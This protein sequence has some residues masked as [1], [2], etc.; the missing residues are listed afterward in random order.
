MALFSNYKTD[1]TFLKQNI[2]NTTFINY[3]WTCAA[4]EFVAYL[5]KTTSWDTKTNKNEYLK[6]Y[7][8][9]CNMYEI[10]TTAVNAFIYRFKYDTLKTD[11]NSTTGTSYQVSASNR[12]TDTVTG[13]AVT[14]PK[15]TGCALNFVLSVYNDYCYPN[16]FIQNCKL[17][18][19]YN[20]CKE[21]LTN[22]A[23]VRVPSDNDPTIFVAQCVNMTIPNCN[24][25][26]GVNVNNSDIPIC[27]TC[28]QGYYWNSTTNQCLPSITPNCLVN[29]SIKQCTSCQ[30]G[31]ALYANPTGVS[32]CFPNYTG[33]NIMNCTSMTVDAV[34]SA[35]S[36]TQLAFKCVA[37]TCINGTFALR[38]NTTLITSYHACTKFSS[39]PFCQGYAL[40]SSG[41]QPI[42]AIP[43]CSSCLTNYYLSTD[44]ANNSAKTCQKRFI[45]QSNCSKQT[46]TADTCDTLG[47]ASGFYLTSGN[48]CTSN[49]TGVYKCAAYDS[50][51]T[52]CQ[53]C[54]TGYYLDTA[55]LCQVVTTTITS[56]SVYSNATTCKQCFQNATSAF[57][58]S[59]SGTSC[60]ASNITSCAMWNAAGDKCS[61]CLPGYLL[62]TDQLTCAKATN[63]IAGCRYQTSETLCSE[64]M[65]GWALNPLQ[66][67]CIY[68]NDTG[69]FNKCS[70]EIIVN[71]PVCVACMPGYTMD[72][73]AS[74]VKDTVVS[75]LNNCVMH[76][77]LDSTKCLICMPGA[78]MT[79]PGV[80]ENVTLNYTQAVLAGIQSRI[81]RSLATKYA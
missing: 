14:A 57:Y 4:S 35:G 11:S 61:K 75:A 42:T 74:C 53:A 26:D 44:T 30:T 68:Q 41:T 36:V 51:G 52:T 73:N 70:N 13:T 17:A 43:D 64:C 19:D 28:A 62:S 32:H 71:Q 20:D 81:Y 63:R 54:Q 33:S 49:P 48:F 50:T 67:A 5:N 2:S 22:F 21:C 6:Y 56:C 25:V 47:C 18:F 59:S 45:S 80:C 38:T 69:A 79:S 10:A 65:T 24:E 34:N 31:Y 15:C 9:M 39:T 60:T 16:D 58:L 55:G 12:V 78:S 27:K 72:N 29:S 3:S 37:N 7:N 8:Y 46:A 1:T 77:P 40:A 76:Q 66:S 23:R